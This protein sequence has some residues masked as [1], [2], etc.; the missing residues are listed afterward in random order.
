MDEV[1]ISADDR[2]TLFEWMRERMIAGALDRPVDWE[3]LAECY[4]V[5]SKVA[6]QTKVRRA[7]DRLLG[8]AKA[9]MPP[10][11]PALRRYEQERGL[12]EPD[13][14]KRHT[15]TVKAILQ[16]YGVDLSGRPNAA[17]WVSVTCPWH[18]RERAGGAGWH[19]AQDLY[20]CFSTECLLPPG[21]V[22]TAE[23]LY[24]ADEAA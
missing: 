19:Q 15:P 2:A 1:G 7:R 13:A 24:L 9:V 10:D 17:G 11:H 23:R 20:R 5:G 16:S 12:V 14:P 18:E 22:L 6:A 8:R 4:H 3:W 21:E